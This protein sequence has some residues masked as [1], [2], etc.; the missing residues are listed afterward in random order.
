MPAG[1]TAGGKGARRRAD[2]LSS[3]FLYSAV[4]FVF[5]EDKYSNISR[6]LYSTCFVADTF[7]GPLHALAGGTLATCLCESCD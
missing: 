4:K 2:F 3:P 6:C 7:S 1:G 5:V